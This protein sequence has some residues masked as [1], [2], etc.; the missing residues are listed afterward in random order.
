VTAIARLAPD[1]LHPDRELARFMGATA[2][3]GAVVS[4]VGIARPASKAGKEVLGLFL[5]HHPSMTVAS[6][7]AIADAAL[8]RFDVSST[9]VVHRCGE[10]APGEPIVFAAAASPHRRAAFLAA[11][12]L[13]DLLKTEAMFWKKEQGRQDG[14]WIEPTEQDRADAARWSQ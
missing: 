10:V 2:G 11:D 3:A 5:D 13:M 1:S 12:F 7:Q 9:C 6:L 14:R 8:A 4:F